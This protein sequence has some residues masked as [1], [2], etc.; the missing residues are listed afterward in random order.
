MFSN[1]YEYRDV[2][3]VACTV[4]TLQWKLTHIL[5]TSRY[6]RCIQYIKTTVTIASS[7]YIPYIVQQ[8][9]AC[10][11]RTFMIFQCVFVFFFLFLF[12]SSTFTVTH[13]F[14][15]SLCKPAVWM[16][17]S[18]PLQLKS[19]HSTQTLLPKDAPGESTT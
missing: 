1:D 5:Y 10:F 13:H 11:F 17:L 3:Y 14:I 8:Q 12:L 4:H 15:M 2:P 19:S 6:K 18:S 7:G 16:A 9:Q